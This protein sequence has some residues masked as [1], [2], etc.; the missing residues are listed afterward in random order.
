MFKPY[1]KDGRTIHATEFAYNAIYKAQGFKPLG[2]IPLGSDE[3]ATLQTAEGAAVGTP[4]TDIQGR[5]SAE[6][7]GAGNRTGKRGR[8]SS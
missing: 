5:G 6:D 1:I 8:K 7:N 2:F 3:N 4:A